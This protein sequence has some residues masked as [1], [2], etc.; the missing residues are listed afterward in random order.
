[1]LIGIFSINLKLKKLNYIELKGILPEVP[2]I[3]ERQ[4][5]ESVHS[6]FRTEKKKK[7]KISLVLIF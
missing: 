4:D 2:R 3:A 7:K 1:M 5:I 6:N